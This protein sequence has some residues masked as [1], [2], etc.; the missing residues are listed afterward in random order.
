MRMGAHEG[1]TD[2]RKVGRTPP[3]FHV[4]ISA[5][6]LLSGPSLAFLIVINWAKFAFV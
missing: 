4:G 1:C 6:E 5:V 2:S 3:E